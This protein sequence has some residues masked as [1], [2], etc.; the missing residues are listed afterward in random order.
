ML[1]ERP[2]A[3]GKDLTRLYEPLNPLWT[4]LTCWI[5]YNP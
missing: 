1:P 4:T 3:K 2:G 5:I